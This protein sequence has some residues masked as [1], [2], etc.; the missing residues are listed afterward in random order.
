MAITFKKV[1][2]S[3]M[4]S[5]VADAIRKA[6]MEGGLQPGERIVERNL[7]AQF[8]A[9]LSVIREALVELET[10]GFVVKRPNAATHVTQVSIADAEKVFR[11]RAVL[12]PHAVAEA[13]KRASPE[14]V[15][16]LEALLDRMMERARAGDLRGYLSEDYRFHDRIWR[17][18]DNEFV[19]SALARALIPFYA[20]FAMRCPYPAFDMQQD[21]DEHRKI[22]EAIAAND[23]VTAEQIVTRAMSQWRT[24]PA[25][26]AYPEKP[27]EKAGA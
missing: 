13:A 5:M 18:A 27:T 4:R 22:L 3:T 11:L 2:V 19:R 9:S 26:Y 23:P 16:E 15:R 17:I 6:I 1:A 7:A 14:D 12:E 8:G 20:F 10:E 24:R 21:A 25:L